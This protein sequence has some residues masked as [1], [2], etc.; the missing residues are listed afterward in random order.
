MTE[1]VRVLFSCGCVRMQCRCPG[2]KRD[3]R[4]S[5]PCAEHAMRELG[6]QGDHQQVRRILMEDR[7]HGPVS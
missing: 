4:L 1:H 5:Y 6:E 2:P 3:E 7:E